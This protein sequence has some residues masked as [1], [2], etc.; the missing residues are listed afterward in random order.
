MNWLEKYRPVSIDDYIGIK[1]NVKVMLRFLEQWQDG[2]RSE[3]Y[4]ILAGVAGVGKTTFAHAA[5]NELGLTIMEVNASDA[6]R[7]ADLAKVG[8]LAAL[9][10]YDNDGR[11][12][13]LDEADGIHDWATVRQILF[14]PQLPIIITANTLSKIPYDIRKE[15]TV[16]NLNHPPEHQ[17]RVLIDRI[18]DGES[19][20]FDEHERAIIAENATS[21]RS[22]INMLSTMQGGNVDADTLVRINEGGDEVVRI[23]TG[24]RILK[25]KVSTGKIMRWG[26]HNMADPRAIQYALM[27]QEAKKTTGMVGAISNTLILTLRAKGNIEAPPFYDRVKKPKAKASEA[28]PAQGMT[29]VKK[30]EKPA[31]NNTFGGF[32]S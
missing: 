4:L 21:W 7:K 16:F 11:I 10:S 1:S 25:P 22:V 13:L 2:M 30:V 20:D 27:F 3:G 12:L 24:D 6:R 31:E 18:C 28:K 23:L 26:A 14:N 5:A 19:L 17:R 9:K 8:D 15:G 29:N 32:F